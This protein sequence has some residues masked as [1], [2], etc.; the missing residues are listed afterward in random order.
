MQAKLNNVQLTKTLK[1]DVKEKMS[2]V[3]AE[4]SKQMLKTIDLI[5]QKSKGDIQRN[6]ELNA[7]LTKYAFGIA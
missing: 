3:D 6:K 2:A 5:E 1:S 4:F 7:E